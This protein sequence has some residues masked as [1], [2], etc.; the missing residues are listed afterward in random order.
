MGLDINLGYIQMRLS[1]SSFFSRCTADSQW[2]S[3]DLG[4]CFSV[5]L[6]C[7]DDWVTLQGLSESQHV[8]G[9]LLGDSYVN[10]DALIT[11]MLIF[12]H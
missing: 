4:R 1:T 7:T 6:I 9:Q 10:S 8:G 11:Q 12:S 5:I 2:H 3:W